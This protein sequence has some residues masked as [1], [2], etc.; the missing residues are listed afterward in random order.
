MDIHSLA[1]LVGGSSTGKTRACWEAV[2]RLRDSGWRL[3]HPIDPNRPNA[4]AEVL[5]EIGPRTVVWLNE[6]Q[7]YL[8]PDSLGERVVAGLRELLRYPGRAPVL[9]LGPLWPE[10]RATLTAT[11]LSWC[12]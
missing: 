9:V 2:Q 4:A 5:S 6:S 7:F 1:V 3:W 11:A 10:H 12:R 8:A